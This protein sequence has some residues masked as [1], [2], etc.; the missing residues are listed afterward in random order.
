MFVYLKEV[1][2]N[3]LKTI[4]LIHGAVAIGALGVLTQ[5][6][7]IAQVLLTA[8]LALAFALVGIMLVGI[9]QVIV[10]QRAGADSGRIVGKLAGTLRWK[11]VAAF[12]R[13]SKRYLP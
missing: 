10:I 2:L 3:G 1:S 9:G 12:G 4:L 8:R 13:Y 5:R 11:K 6:T 7:A